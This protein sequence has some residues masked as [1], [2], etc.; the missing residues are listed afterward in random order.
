MFRSIKLRNRDPRPVLAAVFTV[1]F[2][3]VALSAQAQLHQA[4]TERWDGSPSGDDGGWAVATD[5]AGNIIVAG[6]TGT[7]ANGS[8]ALVIKYDRSG[9]FLWQQTYNG[10]GNATDYWINVAV[11]GSD[12]IVVQGQSD[13]GATSY[14]FVTRVYAGDGTPLWVQRYDGLGSGYDLAFAMDLDGQDNIYAVG[15]EEGTDGLEEFTTIK[16]LPDGTEAWVR[17]YESSSYPPNERAWGEGLAV[18]AGGTVYAGGDAINASGGLDFALLKYDTNGNLLW[19]QLFDSTFGGGDAFRGM[20]L[21]PNEEIYLCGISESASGIEDRVAQYDA[22][23]SFQ[24][25]GRYRRVRRVSLRRVS[26]RRPERQ[27][28]CRREI[29]QHRRV[30]RLGDGLLRHQRHPAVGAPLP[31]VLLCRG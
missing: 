4:W 3:L 27:C 16:Y 31:A 23:G 24:W 8:D 30:F 11:D 22:A 10:P 29:H 14:D 9:K 5:S 12:R 20:A 25:E 13:G 1:A 26:C 2:A 6:E 17:R 15:I 18:T 21:G 7:A 28:L 19:D